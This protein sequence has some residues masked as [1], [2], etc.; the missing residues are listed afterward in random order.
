MKTVV[1]TI[2]LS[3]L[4]CWA[5][6]Q[7]KRAI[8]AAEAGCGPQDAKFEVKSD[9]SQHP[10]PTPEDG[11]ALIY[12]VADGHLTTIFGFDEKWVGAV[13]GGTGKVEAST[14][15]PVMELS[16][17]DIFRSGASRLTGR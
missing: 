1:A 13:N 3:L 7:D 17:H 12:V 5:F 9:G 4:S 10:T 8:S 15:V 11:K 6:A 2:F 14:Q 16:V